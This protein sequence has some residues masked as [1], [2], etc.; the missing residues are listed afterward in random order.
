[1]M[2]KIRNYFCGA[3]VGFINGFFASGGGIVA[4]LALKRYM[5]LDEPPPA[6]PPQPYV[7][8]PGDFQIL[9]NLIHHEGCQGYFEHLLDGDEQQAQA[10]SR[11]TGYVCI[12]R[13]LVNYGDHGTTISDQIAAPGQYSTKDEVLNGPDVNCDYCFENAEWLENI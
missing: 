8:Q 11:V 3:I 7:Q 1:M 10:A 5:K 12:N 4:V 13:A 6:Y 2:H 9:V